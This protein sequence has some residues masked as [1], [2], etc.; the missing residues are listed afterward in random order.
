MPTVTFEGDTHAEIVAKVRKWLAS[1]EQE[2]PTLSPT[3][4]VQAGA[5]LTKE[6]LRIIASAAPK[7][8][9]ESDVVKSLRDMG[10]KATDTTRD[11]M[12]ESLD[13]I[14]SLTGGGVLRR[15]TDAGAKVAF[16]M[17]AAVAKQVL[18]SLRG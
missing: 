18:K 7:P 15:V 4:A 1:T 12:V 17:N 3:E 2:A 5:E 8:V 10:Y 9:A 14:A 13:A 6:A 11:A 16:E